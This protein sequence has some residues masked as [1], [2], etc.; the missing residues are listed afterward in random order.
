MDQIECYDTMLKMTN[1]SFDNG[2]CASCI[3]LS[4]CLKRYN[5]LHRT[6]AKRIIMSWMIRVA[7]HINS[8]DRR[9]VEQWK[10]LET[11]RSN[12]YEVLIDSRRPLRVAFI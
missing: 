10:Y 3:G 1:S 4:S 6:G 5:T 11:K 8:K 7:V 2:Y 9:L 12:M